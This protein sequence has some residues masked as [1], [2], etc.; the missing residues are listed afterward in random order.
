MS[1][2]VVLVIDSFGVGEMAD[3]A[4]V[5]P[6]DIGANTCLHILQQAPEIDID[7]LKKLGL[8]NALGT[9]TGSH[10]Y[11]DNATFGCAELLHEG[12]DTFW[13]HQ[14]IM[15]SL[16]QKPKVAPF[17]LKKQQVRDAL[18]QQGYQVREFGDTGATC[19]LVNEALVIGDNLEAEAGQVY[20]LSGSLDL[21]SFTE[22]KKIG[23]IVRENVQVARVI[24]FAGENVSQE[25]LISALTVKGDCVGL[26]T[27]KT[28][29]YQQG[30]QVVHMGYGIDAG[31]QVPHLLAQH[32]IPTTLIGKVA[33]IV[34]NQYG[35]SYDE[36]VD[37]KTILD[38]TLKEVSLMKKG[39]ICINVQETDLA[40]HNQDLLRYKEV[41]E[42][43]DSY[44]G[45]LLMLL[46]EDDILIVTADHGND[47]TIGH[48]Q[49]TR[50]KVPL[51]IHFGESKS[52]NIGLRSTLADIG[53]TVCD[54]FDVA[55]P[56]S[57]CS[58]LA[59]IQK[60]I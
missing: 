28:G 21:M 15:G 37:T 54:Y 45:K 1:L 24:T 7:N 50:E 35:K 30:Y 55:P 44:V 51:L 6:K 53:A 13:G 49:H 27:P 46:N 20:N 34:D 8:I 38:I 47:P 43:T 36:L 25:N 4:M 19:L 26:D 29:V 41:L 17:F 39:F 56:E 42:L 18:Q 10:Y 2:F 48:S 5:R 52:L 33:D 23:R 14:E 60:Q 22:M 3:V 58:F 31:T 59:Q 40:G 9:Q 57:G 11:N 12:G 32:Q 16:P